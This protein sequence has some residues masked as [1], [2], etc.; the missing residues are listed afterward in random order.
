MKAMKSVLNRKVVL[1]EKH[2]GKKDLSRG[3]NGSDP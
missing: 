3:K 2:F 1:T